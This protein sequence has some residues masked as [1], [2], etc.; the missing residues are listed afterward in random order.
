[1]IIFRSQGGL[2]FELNYKYLDSESHRGNL[3][4]H[5]CKE[6]DLMY[7]KELQEKLENLLTKEYYN[8]KELI[9]LL[10]LKEVQ[11]N[12]AFRKL[13]KVNGIDRETVIRRLMGGRL[14]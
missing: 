5:K 8:I 4:P 6:T 11:A 14:Y 2:D 1:M 3:G 9:D 13:L 12:R 10:G 7:K